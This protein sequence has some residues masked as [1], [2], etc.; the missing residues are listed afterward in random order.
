VII[1]SLK[2]VVRIN[3]DPVSDASSTWYRPGK[4]KLLLTASLRVLKNNKPARHW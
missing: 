4:G 2:V 1:A 3:L